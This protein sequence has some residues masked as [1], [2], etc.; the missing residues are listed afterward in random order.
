[1]DAH[2]QQS[3][4]NRRR[5]VDG[6]TAWQMTLG[7]ISQHHSPDVA[8]SIQAQPVAADRLAWSAA[9]VWGQHI[10]SVTDEESLESALAHLWRAVA[11]Y[12]DVFLS[13][14]DAWRAPADY[15]ETEWV[16]ASVALVV[17]RV[18]AMMG[19]I[20]GQDWRLNLVYQPAESPGQR[21]QARLLAGD[22]ALCVGSLGPTLLQAIR[23]LFRSAVP[24]LCAQIDAKRQLS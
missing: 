17:Q 7:Y 23:D 2:S 6:W 3:G 8:L 14:D 9:L 16:D 21:V 18:L 10:E 13:P 12:H 4:H 20:S 11:C 1:V 24:A 19:K 22:N 15:A 5:P